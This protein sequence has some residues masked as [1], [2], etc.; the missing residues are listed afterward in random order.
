M[1]VKT[2]IKGVEIYASPE[3]G[4]VTFSE[5]SV[6]ASN[7]SLRD[8]AQAL[9]EVFTTAKQVAKENDVEVELPFFS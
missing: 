4:K 9:R 3:G 8:Y 1:D 5:I 2:V 6:D 7:I